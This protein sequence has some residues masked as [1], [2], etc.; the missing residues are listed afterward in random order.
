[1]TTRDPAAQSDPLRS[2]VDPQS[3]LAALPWTRHLR[4]TLAELSVYDVPPADPAQAR[5]HANECPEPWPAEVMAELGRR[6]QAVEFGRYP[7]SDFFG[8]TEQF[9]AKIAE[10]EPVFIG[11]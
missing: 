5:M 10:F 7:D 6:L 3:E 9:V 1:M 8:D 4:P 2:A 11:K